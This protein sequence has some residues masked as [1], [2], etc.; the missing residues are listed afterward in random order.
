MTSNSGNSDKHSSLRK[1][2]RGLPRVRTSVD[3]EARLR[4]RILEE[5]TSGRKPGLE[6]FSFRKVPAFAYSL[7]AIAVVGFT[8][9]YLFL[10][11]QL[12]PVPPAEEAP[13]V[14]RPLQLKAPPIPG[15]R[16]AENQPAAKRKT[17]NSGTPRSKAVSPPENSLSVQRPAGGGAE[18]NARM[19][20]PRA[21][22]VPGRDALS[23]T[24]IIEDNLITD[25]TSRTDSLRLDSTRRAEE[26]RNHLRVK[27]KQK[28][29]LR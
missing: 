11:S 7:L 20:V 4:R 18:L 26:Q 28:K 16:S 23:K 6:Y 8:A 2:L 27:S 3:F 14:Q 29:P 5:T 25:T 13:V 21:I 9:Y 22:A 1:L 19:A 15:L 24:G 12:I 17:E 10:P